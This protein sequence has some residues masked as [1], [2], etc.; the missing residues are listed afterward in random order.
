MRILTTH[1]T[2]PACPWAYSARPWHAALRWRFGD[3]LDWRLVTIGLSESAERYEAL[4]YTPERQVASNRVFAERFGMPYAYEPKAR[5]S[6][7]SPGCRAI[8]AA[9][10]RD[11]ALAEPALRALQDLQFTTTGRLDDRAALRA[12]LETIGAGDLADRID[13]PDVVAAYEAD[14]ALARSAAGGPTDVQ[15]RAASTDGPVRF[16]APSVIFEHPTGARM[17][18]GGFQPLEVYDTALANLEPTLER[19]PPAGDVEQALA[20][21]PEGLV[22]AEVAWIRKTDLGAL[23]L[24]G[25]RAALQAAAGAGVVERVALGDDARWALLSRG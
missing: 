24:D 5:L 14:R 23:D 19:R 8:V 1:F 18:V 4:G 6:A 3:Q 20:A 2:D 25:T 22:T 21:F 16:T 11:P 10:L 13:D 17:E 15:G 12:A 9:R 7:S